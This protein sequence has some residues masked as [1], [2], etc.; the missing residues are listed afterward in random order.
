MPTRLKSTLPRTSCALPCIR[1]TSSRRS[2]DRQWCKRRLAAQEPP[3]RPSAG[4]S[5]SNIGACRKPITSVRLIERI[6]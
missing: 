3:R 6:G 1:P 2:G 5:G 4:A